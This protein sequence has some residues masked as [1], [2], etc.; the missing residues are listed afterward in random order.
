MQL[1]TYKA[2]TV[3]TVTVARASNAELR[4]RVYDAS[5]SA[6]D[7]LRYARHHTDKSR[8]GELEIVRYALAR[9]MYRE[10]RAVSVAQLALLCETSVATVA[11]YMRKFG[12]TGDMVSCNDASR[13]MC[14]IADY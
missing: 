7:V 9:A 2:P 11:H 13:V 5:A 4:E 14:N 8:T 10:G 6:E 12:L 1:T 3:E